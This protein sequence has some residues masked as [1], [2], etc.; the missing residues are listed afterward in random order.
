MSR[1]RFSMGFDN[2]NLPLDEVI[3]RLEDNIDA[4]TGAT[5]TVIPPL[6]SELSDEDS[7]DEDDNSTTINNLTGNFLREDVEVSIKSMHQDD[8]IGIE[9]MSRPGPSSEHGQQLQLACDLSTPSEVRRNTRSIVSKVDH[10]S[11]K[12]RRITIQNTCKTAVAKKAKTKVKVEQP[13]KKSHKS[14]T[15]RLNP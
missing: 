9:D 8:E 4:W 3:R 5:V 10:V 2:K 14:Q 1:P 13:M 15:V 6:P 11:P 7:G 12:K